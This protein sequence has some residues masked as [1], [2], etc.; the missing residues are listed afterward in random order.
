MAEIIQ[1]E[2]GGKKGGKRRPKKSS[3]HID[4][5]PMVDLMCLLLTFFMLTSALNKPKV[6][7]VGLPDKDQKEKNKDKIPKWRTINIIMDANDK[8]YYY[9]GLVERPPYPDL[10]ETNYSKDGIRKLLLARN[11]TLFKNIEDL[12]TAVVKGKKVMPVDTLR[13]R[14][15]QLKRD[16]KIG[17]IVLIKATDKAKYK[18]IVD[19]IDEMAI[20]DVA[21]YA[22]VDMNKPEQKM[23]DEYKKSHGETET[24]KTK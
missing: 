24:K 15:L 5:T 10:I 16:D 21:H 1:N 23:L 17:P 18:N 2:G 7:E 12:N 4:M 11:K 13:K 3:T 20:C 6:M 14:I 9:T 8:V 22:L 19:V